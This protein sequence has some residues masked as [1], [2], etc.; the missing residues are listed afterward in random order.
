[1]IAVCVR[2]MSEETKIGLSCDAVKML[3]TKPLMG[4][5]IFVQPVAC[6]L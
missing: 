6:V 2:E 3:E 5:R 1:M 4:V